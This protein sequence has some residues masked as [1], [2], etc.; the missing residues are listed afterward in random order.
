LSSL[1]EIFQRF[2]DEVEPELKQV[3]GS[4]APTIESEVKDF[5]FTIYASPYIRVLIDGR[6]P[7]S[8]GATKGNPTLQMVILD[9]IQRKSIQPDKPNMTQESLSWAISKSIHKKGTLLYQRGGGNRIF[10]NILTVDREEKLLSL[11]SDFYFTKI[12]TIART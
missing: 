10:D 5:S 3:V 11:I 9:W 2:I 8:E 4:F 12:T 1:K 6:K 7:T